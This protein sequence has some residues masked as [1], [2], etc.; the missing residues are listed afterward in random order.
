[1]RQQRLLLPIFAIDEPMH[2]QP[3][4]PPSF[5]ILKQHRS[6]RNPPAHLNLVPFPH[7]LAPLPTFALMASVGS[8][9]GERTFADRLADSELAPYSAV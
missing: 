4:K 6:T 3:P 5:R 1:V 7:I 8:L 2:R 9:G